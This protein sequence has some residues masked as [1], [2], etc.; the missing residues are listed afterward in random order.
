MRLRLVLFLLVFSLLASGPGLVISDETKL[1]EVKDLYYGEVLY[2]LYQQNHFTAIVHLLAARQQAHLKAHVEDAELLLGGLY[3]AYGMPDEAERQFIDTLQLTSS[4]LIQ[5][6]I[7]MQ[8][9]KIRYR[10][11]Q[12]PAAIETLKKIGDHLTEDQD[13]ER[14]VLAGLAAL[15][16]RDPSTAQEQLGNFE[17]DSIWAGYALFNRALSLIGTDQRQLA[18]E[19]LAEI[20]QIDADD[21][22]SKALRDRA[23]LLRG[24]LLLDARQA[25]AAREALQQ[26]RLTSL[27]ANQALLGVG[28]SLLQEGK[29]RSALPSW[30]ELSQR[31]E[32]DAAVY[33]ALLAIPY[34]FS[35]LEAD[36][37]AQEHYQL[38]IQRFTSDQQQ[39][40]QTIASLRNGGL[41]QIL[42]Q[43]EEQPDKLPQLISPLIASHN[44]QE[45]YKDYLDLMF[46]QQN[47]QYWQESIDAFRT[48]LDTR[49][50]AYQNNLPKVEQK[51]AGDEL[52]RL[53]QTKQQLELQISQATSEQEPLFALATQEEKAQLGRISKIERM[54]TELEPKMEMSNQRQQLELLRGM[55]IWRTQTDHPARRW[56]LQKAFNQ[57]EQALGRAEQQQQA[58]EQAHA[59]VQG[60][61]DGFAR[62]IGELEKRIPGLLEEVTQQRAK[63]ALKLESMAAETLREQQKQINDYLIQARFGLASLLDRNRHATGDKP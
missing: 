28:W 49:R 21:E 51:L 47:L 44:F 14:Q 9:A 2:Q 36:S 45:A 7:W 18:L 40:E 41:Q 30:L 63:L 8:L 10:R 26:I 20:N 62:R 60:R 52:S 33:E 57:L 27:S 56:K 31:S 4:P 12:Q 39:L 15:K 6:R 19:Q 13:Q 38:A 46:L 43:A 59:L 3:L 23:N 24:Y 48:M 42:E 58:L 1:K 16:N 25:V 17:G 32:H 11:D 55:L 22:E 5:D 53:Q 54:L 50:L 34:A 61:I 29:P 35:L 37:S